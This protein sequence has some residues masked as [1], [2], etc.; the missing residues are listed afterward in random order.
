MARQPVSLD[1]CW[2]TVTVIAPQ[3]AESDEARVVVKP[4]PVVPSPVVQDV[5]EGEAVGTTM[6]HAVAGHLSRAVVVGAD[7]VREVEAATISFGGLMFM[8][9]FIV[10]V[11]NSTVQSRRLEVLESRINAYF[12]NHS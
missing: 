3:T 12:T 8:I 4:R 7:H 1:D 10:L 6:F 5:S 11:V 2:A 9:I